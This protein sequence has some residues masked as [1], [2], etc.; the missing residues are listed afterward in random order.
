MREFELENFK[1]LLATKSLNPDLRPSALI[2]GRPSCARKPTFPLP[3]APALSRAT[4]TYS[5]LVA[6]SSICTRFLL[7]TSSRLAMICGL[8]GVSCV[9]TSPL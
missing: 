4:N 7:F 6:V 1:A 5:T 9:S 3:T 2:S 8:P